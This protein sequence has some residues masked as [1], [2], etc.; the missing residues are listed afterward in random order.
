MRE[1]LREARKVLS[2]V[3]RPDATQDSG[4][5]ERVLECTFRLLE[6][7]YSSIDNGKSTVLSSSDTTVV[8]AILELVVRWGIYPHLS[9]G[10]GIPLEKRFGEKSAASAAA[11][12]KE[13]VS[14][15]GSGSSVGLVGAQMSKDAPSLLQ[16]AELLA[17]L[18][19]D[20]PQKIN[21]E[22][23]GL[24]ATSIGQCSEPSNPTEKGGETL[25][26]ATNLPA[27]AL[28]QL[29]MFHHLPDLC[30][31]FIQLSLSGKVEWK[32]L[33]TERINQMVKVLPVAHMV[34][35][36]LTLLGQKEPGPPHWL[37][38]NAGRMLSKLVMRRGGVAASME[39]LV[40]GIQEGNVKAYEHIALHLAK[41]P[42]YVATTQEYYEAI[43][44]Q[45]PPLILA[46]LPGQEGGLKEGTLAA[47]LVVNMHHTAIIMACKLASRDIKLFG[48]Y[49]LI[50]WL[51]PLVFWGMLAQGEGQ[52]ELDT[53][54]KVVDNVSPRQSDMQGATLEDGCYESEENMELLLVNALIGTHIFLTAGHEGADSVR[55]FLVPLIEP[56]SEALLSL[57]V[58]LEPTRGKFRSKQVKRE[59][60]FQ[61]IA[62]GLGSAERAHKS[63]S[64]ATST[65]SK[66]DFEKGFLE[67]SSLGY[68]HVEGPSSILD[69]LRAA[70]SDIVDLLHE[71]RSESPSVLPP[72]VL[73]AVKMKW[74]R[75]NGN[76]WDALNS[77][78]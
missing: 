23:S 15:E 9:P 39:R 6:S 38:E 47:R 3:K 27:A 49:L 64:G 51:K 54:T 17:G 24:D 72:S 10:V 57:K 32:K 65:T 58:L 13:H 26:E 12:L 5:T 48:E 40:G 61:P 78:R 56:T 66:S 46:P 34:E 2:S 45:L 77:D 31:A 35:A 18:I 37:K 68:A 53:K 1:A 71:E 19:L 25:T 11:A 75:H 33:A 4:A 52:L 22:P 14:G 21:S 50:P 41:V 62:E 67:H 42:R 7:V 28:H 63:E 55:S 30:A 36:L 8:K 74:P 29:V 20:S 43:S 16:S 73:N 59:G 70:L 60:T 76:I 69:R 44:P